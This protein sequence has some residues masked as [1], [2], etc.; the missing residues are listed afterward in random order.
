MGWIFSSLAT[1]GRRTNRG[2]NNISES[3]DRKVVV[4][5]YTIIGKKVKGGT[6]SGYWLMGRK[7]IVAWRGLKY[8]TKKL[9]F[10]WKT[11]KLELEHLA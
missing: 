9:S 7:L 1:R 3:M 4:K 8:T 5:I 6:L 2:K 10:R 11:T